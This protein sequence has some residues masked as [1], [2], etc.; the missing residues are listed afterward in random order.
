MANTLY[1]YPH[2]FHTDGLSDFCICF[3]SE[4]QEYYF[5]IELA[6][7]FDDEITGPQ[8]HVNDILN[9]LTEWMKE[10]GYRTDEPLSF[11]EYFETEGVSKRYKTIEKAYTAFRKMVHGFLT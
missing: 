1:S 6:V 2:K 10:N 7:S 8:H 11:W 4:N 9:D 3:D 5:E